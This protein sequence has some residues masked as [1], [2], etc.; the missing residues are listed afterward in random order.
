[1]NARRLAYGVMLVVTC[2]RIRS[3][4][5]CTVPTANSARRCARNV[6][7]VRKNYWTSRR[8]KRRRMKRSGDIH[9]VFQAYL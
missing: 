4:V 5:G 9:V 1:M 3:A 8:K 2:V 7:S 6:V